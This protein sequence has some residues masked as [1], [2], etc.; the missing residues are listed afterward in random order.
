[1]ER[2]MLINGMRHLSP[3]ESL[4]AIKEGAIL[5]DLRNEDL[6]NMKAF[7]VEGIIYCPYRDFEKNYSV[8]PAD[9]TVILADSVGLRSK[10]CVQVLLDHGYT[11]VA[12][13]AGGI[14]D[15]EKDGLP[16]DRD[17]KKD[18]NGPCMCMLRPG[19]H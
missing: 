3:T 8:I 16:L 6:V 15:W 9:K 12:N 4:E 11:L 13:M 7:A 18:L 14:M 2:G 19:K 17:R 1:M 10:E 5:V